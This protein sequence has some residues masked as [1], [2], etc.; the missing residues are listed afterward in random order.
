[1]GQKQHD[2][3][4]SV[5]RLTLTRLRIV[6]AL[7]HSGSGRK[8]RDDFNSKIRN[9]ILDTVDAMSRPSLFT[10]MEYRLSQARGEKYEVDHPF[11]RAR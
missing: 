2:P 10:Q 11:P 6:L 1:M 4:R 3:S 8:N 5:K 7:T 9:I